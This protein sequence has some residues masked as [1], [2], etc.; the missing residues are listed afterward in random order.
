MPLAPG[1]QIQKQ[2]LTVRFVPGN[3]PHL[4]IRA[5]Y[6]LANVGTTPLDSIEIGLPSQKGFGSGN[7]HVKINGREIQLQRESSPATQPAEGESATSETWPTVWRIPF[8]SRWSRRQRKNLVVEYDL[9]ATAATDPRMSIAAN[10]FYLNDSGWFPDP[11]STKALFATDVV[12]PDPSNLIVDVPATFVVTAS[13]GPRG[14]HKTNN[15]TEYRFR[16]HKDD[17]DPYVVAGQ[18]TKQFVSSA[19]VIFWSAESLSSNLQQPAAA[20][21]QTFQFYLRFLGPLPRDNSTIYV[22]NTDTH[23]MQRDFLT[24]WQDVPPAAIFT[25]QT[26]S[27][28]WFAAAFPDLSA[29]ESLAATWLIHLVTPRPEAWLLADGLSAYAAEL[30]EQ[31]RIG[32]PSRTAEISPW[33]SK[34]DATSKLAVERPL[35][36]LKPTDPFAPRRLA[37]DKI[38]LFFFALE[39]RCERENVEHAIAHMVYALRG[40]EYG[41][42]DFRAAL[43]QE[44]HQDLSSSFDTWLDQKG[45][46]ADFRAR[47]ENKNKNTR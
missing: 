32:G 4:A 1:Y 13:G 3:P 40:Q 11:I 35:I 47:Y 44:C 45:I 30:V 37:E 41:Y 7:F 46:P 18:Y 6:R 39:D 21:A 23:P 20:L 12:R 16:L 24:P 28:P 9:A 19:N 29:E 17:F 25:G 33:L 22:I 36:S 38:V 10:A 8:A 15:E 34:F 31:A 26:L 43:E 2:T 27:N 5:Q 42:T 14:T